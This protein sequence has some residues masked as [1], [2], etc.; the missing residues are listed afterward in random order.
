MQFIITQNLSAARREAGRVCVRGGV[1]ESLMVDVA[2]SVL[3]HRAAA[4]LPSLKQEFG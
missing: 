2:H 4:V 1:S 3:N